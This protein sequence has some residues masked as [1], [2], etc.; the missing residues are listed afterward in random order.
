MPTPPTVPQ[1]IHPTGAWEPISLGS[2]CAVKFQTSRRMYFDKYGPRGDLHEC[3]RTLLTPERGSSS[4]ERHVFDWAITPFTAVRH[5]LTVGFEG[6]Y[7]RAD[8]V[9][10][11]GEAVNAVHRTRHPHDFHAGDPSTGLTDADIDAQYASARGKFD[12]LARRF[13]GLKDRPGRYLYVFEGFPYVGHVAE[14]LERLGGSPEHDFML[15]LVGY[16]DEGEQP[17]ETLGERL[18]WTRIPRAVDKAAEFRW[19]G[20]DPSWD[21]ALAPYRLWPHHEHMVRCI[22]EPDAVER[23]N[24]VKRL[25]GWFRG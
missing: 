9:I 14:V 6:M 25:A 7:E 12:H 2:T 13:V 21:A 24:L 16:D 11:D 17:Y 23:P 1:G 18:A 15:L 19:E 3:R 4:Y 22:D 10:E 20:D 5:A 8:L